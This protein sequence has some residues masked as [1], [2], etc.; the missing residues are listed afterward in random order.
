MDRF[1]FDQTGFVIDRQDCFWVSGEF[2][3]FRVPR[4]DWRRRMELFKQAGGNG[5]ATYVPWLM[6]E[7]EEG[8]FDFGQTPQL[9]LPHFLKTAQEAGL[10]VLLRPGPYQYSELV[11][12]GLPTWLL[13]NYP[14][15]LARDIRQKPFRKSSI[16]YLHP[17]LLSKAR[18]YYRAFADVVRPWMAENGGPVVMLQADNE[19]SG[20]HL[21]FGSLDYH[22]QA[23]GFG[24]RDGRW[25]QF[26]LKKYAR[27]ERLNEAYGTDFACFEDVRPIHAPERKEAAACRRMRDYHLFYCEMMGEYLQTLAGWMREDGLHA[28][29]CHNAANPGM[30]SLF[31]ET[32]GRMG[33]NFLLGSDHYYTLNQH[34]DQNNPTPQYALKALLSMELMKNLGMPPSV[35]E[36]PG[37]SPSD[38]PPILREDLQACYFTNLAMGMKGVNYYVYTGGPNLPGTGATTD[39]Y[40]YQALVHADG[41]LNETYEAAKAFGQFAASHGWMQRTERDAGVQV[42]FEW[43]QMRC[44]DYEWR[45]QPVTGEHGQEFLRCGVLYSLLCSRYS[46]RLTALSG[47]LDRGQPLI[48]PCTSAMSAQAQK[49]LVDF[50]AGGGKLLLLG[51]LPEM[52]LDY[53]PMTLLRDALGVSAVA[54]AEEVNR[55]AFTSGKVVYGIQQCYEI[56]QLPPNAQLLAKDADADRVLGFS[57]SLGQGRV[58][59]IGADWTLRTFDQVQMLE[60]VLQ[61]FDA[62]PSVESAN[63]N[64]F[65]A[66]W[67]DECGHAAVFAMNLF[68]GAQKTSIRAYTNRGVMEWKA[69]TLAPMEVRV[70]EA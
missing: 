66:L 6:H 22:A 40:D 50:A 56:P 31:V 41:S 64:I 38:T 70:L 43:E 69:L 47:S 16:S 20:I 4:Q 30:N 55:V 45:N 49:A 1:R 13:E 15:V 7:P 37:G 61:A 3:Y 35:M 24:Q 53:Q 67:Q 42:G 68:S 5:I 36:M 33:E 57:L 14:E 25:S 10:K 46:P 27:I 51:T 59:W 8:F 65:T 2:H 52:D 39:L 23:M 58:C 11:N 44:E 21:W 32:V 19:L 17:I 48:I 60:D 28:P 29:V 62:R 26:L 9:D 18:A 34:W 54:R 63:R 12:D